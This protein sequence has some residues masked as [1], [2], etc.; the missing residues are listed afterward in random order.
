MHQLGSKQETEDMGH[1]DRAMHPTGNVPFRHQAFDWL[2]SQG[3]AALRAE[4]NISERPN[5]FL[6]EGRDH[7]IAWFNEEVAFLKSKQD[8][9]IWIG[10]RWERLFLLSL[11]GF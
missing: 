11:E 1:Q 3:S 9:R 8:C 4:I 2:T 6:I 5:E 10:H 7:P